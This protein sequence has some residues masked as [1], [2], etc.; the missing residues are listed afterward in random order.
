MSFMY[1]LT[2]STSA[3]EKKTFPAELVLDRLSQVLG[4]G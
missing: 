1:V 3:Q 2:N 4:V